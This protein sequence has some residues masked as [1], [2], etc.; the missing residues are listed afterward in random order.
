MQSSLFFTRSSGAVAMVVRPRQP[1][2][3]HRSPLP[4]VMR[5]HAVVSGGIDV[6]GCS[7]TR[8]TTIV[9]AQAGSSGEENRLA[10]VEPRTPFGEMLTYYLKMEPQLFKTAVEDQLN[11]LK[12]E[13]EAQKAKDEA[14]KELQQA[15][16]GADKSELILYQRM[17]EMRK[18]ELKATLEDLMYISVLEKFVE[19]NIDMMPRID[20]NVQPTTNLSA[21]TEGVHSKEAIELVKEHVLSVMGPAAMAFSQAQVR[22]S[23]LQMAQVYA[24]SVMFGYF[25]RRV[26]KRFQLAQSFGML[27][28]DQEDAAQTLEKLFNEA[29]SAASSDDLDSPSTSSSSSGAGSGS[30]AGIGQKKSPL[31]KYVESFD[32][33]TMKEMARMVSKEGSDLVERQTVGLF[34]DIKTLQQEMQEAVGTDIMSVEDLMQKVESAVESGAVETIVITV[35]TQRRAVLEAVAFGTFLRDVETWVE[36]D[37]GLLTALPPPDFTMGP[38]GPGPVA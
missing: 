21:L 31:R 23:K 10:P 8:G 20:D 16:E 4:A 34:G 18:R 17:E 9:R 33:E 36:N 37:Y 12:D 22:L 3:L 29:A 13:I 35:G 24:A 30:S 7:R 14:A 19:L 25:L 27:P 2:R 26:D 1:W 5:S 15:E 32:E 38:G 11:H 6:R 28:D